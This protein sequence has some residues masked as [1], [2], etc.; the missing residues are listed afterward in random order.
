[1]IYLILLVNKMI[2]VNF[3]KLHIE[4]WQFLV[5]NPWKKKRDWPGWA[6]LGND[7]CLDSGND[8]FACE[9]TDYYI[10]KNNELLWMNSYCDKYCPI[11]GTIEGCDDNHFSIFRCWERANTI[12][13]RIKYAK[14]I[15]DAEWVGEK[16]YELES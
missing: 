14:I 6:A 1:M 9:I 7:D 8:C 12:E 16:M 10:E 11:Y 13:D 5:D 15:R 4:L 3:H 2:K